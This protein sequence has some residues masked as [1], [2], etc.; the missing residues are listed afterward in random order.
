MALSK[1]RWLG[2]VVATVLTAAC[3]SASEEPGEAARTAEAGDALSVSLGVCYHGMTTTLRP[4]DPSAPRC[5]LGDVPEA[6]DYICATSP[7][8]CGYLLDTL[9]GHALV[10]CTP[11]VTAAGVGW[12]FDVVDKYLDGS[13][14]DGP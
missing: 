2:A 7:E 5:S 14:L 9:N 8:V 4:V 12:C 10:Q 1:T 11:E 6:V 3:S 13:G